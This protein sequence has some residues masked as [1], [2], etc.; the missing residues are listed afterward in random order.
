M[1][2]DPNLL[3]PPLG[4]VPPSTPGSER[5]LRALLADLYVHGE[6][7]VRQEVELGKAELTNRVDKAK[8]AL[9]RGAISAGLYYAAYLTT[10]ATIVLLLA[11][12]M[13][14]W[15]AA[16]VVAVAAGAGAVVFTLLGKQALDDVKRPVLADES[17]SPKSS[18][19]LTRQRA[20]S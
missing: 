14:P 20:H 8:V 19:S 2:Q 6:T 11:E 16:L 12:W 15:I 4:A 17:T 9:R 7:L 10:L 13:A 18:S 1:S 3:R 5:E